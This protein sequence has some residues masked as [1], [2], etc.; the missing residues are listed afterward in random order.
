MKLY[1]S[2]G[3]CSLSPH[4]VLREAGL[5]F[6]LQRVDHKTKTIETPGDFY[7]INSKGYVPALELDNGQILTE[8]PAI[9]QYLADLKPASQLAPP[10]GTLERSRL[11]EWLNYVSSEIHK[12]YSPLFNKTLPAEQ[13]AAAIESLTK[14]LDWTAQQ[15][16]GKQFL[17]GDHFTVADAYL[18]AVLRWS[19]FTGIDL[20]RWSTLKTY[21][22]R[23]AARPKVN[24]AM[25]AEGII[26]HA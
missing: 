9:V 15:L 11:Q 8:G 19:P 6:S 26:K 16:E 23:I 17:I 2:P 18:F 13:R 22:D 4:I 14:R 25:V 12:G 21:V 5:D 3:A 24:E 1:F 20:S 10:N 7:K